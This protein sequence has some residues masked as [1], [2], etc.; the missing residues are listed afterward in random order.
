MTLR[1][2]SRPQGK[3]LIEQLFPRCANVVVADRSLILE[4]ETDWKKRNGFI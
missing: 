2:R 3:R 4:L 1:E